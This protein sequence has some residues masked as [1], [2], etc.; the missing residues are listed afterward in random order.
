MVCEKNKNA[1]NAVQHAKKSPL[2][3]S[4]GLLKKI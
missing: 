4:R 2:A 3:K 1:H